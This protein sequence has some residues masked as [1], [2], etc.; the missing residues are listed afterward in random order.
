M[1]SLIK[2]CFLSVTYLGLVMET[3]MIAQQEWFS[4]PT[5]GMYMYIYNMKAIQFLEFR[6]SKI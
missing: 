6:E 5:S 2:Q 4:N 3:D 1:M